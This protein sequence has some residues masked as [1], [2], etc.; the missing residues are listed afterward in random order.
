MAKTKCRLLANITSSE[1]IVRLPNNTQE[2]SCPLAHINPYRQREPPPAPQS[3]TLPDLFFGKSVPLPEL[4]I[5]TRL[6]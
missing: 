5:Q 4:D 1:N 2:V 3:E 6:H